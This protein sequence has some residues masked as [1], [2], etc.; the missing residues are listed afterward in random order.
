MENLLKDNFRASGRL[1]LEPL[2]IPSGWMIGIN[3][4]YAH[5]ASLGMDLGS[6]M[7]LAWNTGRRFK[8]EIDYSRSAIRT[9]ASSRR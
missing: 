5:L 4:L 8:I 6:S 3:S 1:E 9:E 7:F 2:R